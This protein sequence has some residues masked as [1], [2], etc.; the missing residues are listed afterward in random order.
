MVLTHLFGDNFGFV[1]TTEMEYGLPARTFTS[2][3][4]AA[5]EAAISRLYGGI[6]YEMAI[7]EGLTQGNQIGNYIVKNLTTLKPDSD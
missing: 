6:H 5:E 3:I 4:Q 7:T 2:F 1:D